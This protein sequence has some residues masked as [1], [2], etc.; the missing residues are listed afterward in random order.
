M[1][2]TSFDG[3]LRYDDDC[4]LARLD[5]WIPTAKFPAAV[6]VRWRADT[7]ISEEQL[8]ELPL[9]A[10][11]SS[12]EAVIDELAKA[13]HAKLGP[14][15]SGYFRIR[16]SARG[17]AASPDVDMHRHVVNDVPGIDANLQT[18]KELWRAERQRNEQLIS[19]LLTNQTAHLEYFGT[20]GGHL[21]VLATARVAGSVG[22]DMANPMSILGML[23]WLMF[24]PM[25]KRSMGLP[26][27]ADL[28]TV[29]RAG[30][31]YIER[32]MGGPTAQLPAPE[33]TLRLQR[34]EASAEPEPASKPAAIAESFRWTDDE[35]VARAAA[36]LTW[37]EKLLRKA[38][39][40]PPLR[41]LATRIGFEMA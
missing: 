17:M 20:V 35:V 37:A 6:K 19:A 29:V 38:M 34:P 28:M 8:V 5:K 33:G 15:P 13:I 27:N 39:T 10:R 25:I 30:Q 9:A 2:P 36:D 31:A 40:I 21:S 24:Q 11:P 14:Q 16:A 32:G 26:D 22:G 41:E 23:A 18:Y 12:A 1:T 7:S 4:V 3:Y